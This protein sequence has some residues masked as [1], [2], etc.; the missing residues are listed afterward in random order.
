MAISCTTFGLYY[1]LTEDIENDMSPNNSANMMIFDIDM[2]IVGVVT[3]TSTPN[4]SPTA[5]SLGWLSLTSMV[6]YIIGF[7]FGWG[8]VPWIVMS[9]VF[10][11][12]A[13]GAASSIAATVC[14]LTSF[15]VTKSF[16]V[17]KV[18]LSSVRCG[19]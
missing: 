13:R 18:S 4:V 1:K 16:L 19:Y 9:E 14:W 8:P 5:E 7:S 6:V 11:L 12:K 10:P 17:L 3:P 15:A 2:N